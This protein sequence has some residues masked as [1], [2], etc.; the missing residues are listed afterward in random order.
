MYMILLD[1]ID[2]QWLSTEWLNYKQTNILINS[3]VKVYK[4]EI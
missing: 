3:K 2:Y 4:A 1:A